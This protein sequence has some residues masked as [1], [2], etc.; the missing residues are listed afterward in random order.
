MMGSTT[1][2]LQGASSITPAFGSTGAF[3]AG[4]ANALGTSGNAALNGLVP[5]AGSVPSQSPGMLSTLGGKL[6][7]NA[8]E[9][10]LRGGAMMAGGGQQQQQQFAPQPMMM[11]RRPYQPMPMRRVG[12]I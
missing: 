4:A 2:A 3:N 9:L 8:P 1:G 11:Q 7:D 6:S 5:A 12:R 10:M